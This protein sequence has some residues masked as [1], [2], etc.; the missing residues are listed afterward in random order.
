MKD[1]EKRLSAVDALA[2]PWIQQKVSSKFNAKLANK[3]INN[4]ASFNVRRHQFEI[5]TPYS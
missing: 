5:R 3:S 1:P 2:H 4:L